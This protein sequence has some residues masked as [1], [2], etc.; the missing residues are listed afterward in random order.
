MLDEVYEQPEGVRF[1]RQIVERKL[2]IPLL[3][4]GDEGVGRRFSVVQAVK[5]LFCIG[6]RAASCRCYNCLQ[7]DHGVH[8]DF[9]VVRPDNGEVTVEPIRELVR[10]THN[11]PM[12]GPVKVFVIDGADK[13]NAASANALLKT[14]EEP[15]ATA[16]FFLL[17]ESPKKVIPTIRSRCGLVRYGPLSEPF[18]V[19]VLQ[20]SGD[21]CTKPLII[22]RMSEGSVGRAVQYMGAGRLAFRDK[23]LGLLRLAIENNVSGLFT[24]ID[25][26]EKELPLALRFLE[27]VVHDVI[28]V[29]AYP[30]HVIHSDLAEELGKIRD[31]RTD[32]DLW[33]QLLKDVHELRERIRSRVHLPFQLKSLFAQVFWV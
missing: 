10:A 28:M 4:V 25:A 18:I 9:S 23:V 30:S 20:R 12:A 27:Q 1:L 19:S 2:S 31:R 8:P 24:S 33:H 11:Y 29:R 32:G 26:I 16:L 22:A 7:V 13:M 17:A 3:L 21:D 15:P 6:T 5:E 14:L